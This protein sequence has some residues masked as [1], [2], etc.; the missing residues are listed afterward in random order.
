MRFLISTIQIDKEFWQIE[1][2]WNEFLDVSWVVHET[3][4]HCRHRVELSV[5]H[6]KPKGG[7]QPIYFHQSLNTECSKYCHLCAKGR[8]QRSSEVI[9]QDHTD[10]NQETFDNCKAYNFN[11]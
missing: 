7:V 11:V 1:E 8:F 9:K 4:P 5:S 2:L 6:V 10:H 3:V